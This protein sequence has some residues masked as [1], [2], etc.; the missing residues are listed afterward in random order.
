MFKKH[1]S[2]EEHKTLV[3]MLEA[4]KDRQ[5]IADTIGRSLE[6]V[7]KQARK[8]GYKILQVQWTP[9]L[10]AKFKELW[11][12]G[13]SYT[14]IQQQIGVSEKTAKTFAKQF[15]FGTKPRAKLDIAWSEEEENALI[16]MLDGGLPLKDIAKKLGRTTRAVELRKHQV[17]TN[18]IESEPVPMPV[19]PA[20]TPLEF[21][22]VY[23]QV[24]SQATTI[25]MVIFALWKIPRYK[26]PVSIEEVAVKLVRL[27][28]RGPAFFHARREWSLTKW[29]AY[30][31]KLSEEDLT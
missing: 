1:Y 27:A 12:S 11:K 10:K 2:D 23:Q 20:D 13:A 14:E 30:L 17:W 28:G 15:G 19:V 9:E 16:E 22:Q 25:E 21:R 7:N 3:R 18:P 8:M 5:E 26:R 31:A 4:G 6:S 24:L 29:L